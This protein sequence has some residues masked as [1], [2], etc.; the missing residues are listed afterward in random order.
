MQKWM[1][2]NTEKIADWGGDFPAGL[3][4]QTELQLDSINQKLTAT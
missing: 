3:N 1:H 2:A 4:V